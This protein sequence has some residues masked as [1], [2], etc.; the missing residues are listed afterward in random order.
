LILTGKERTHLIEEL[1]GEK[2]Q[3]VKPTATTP[4]KVDPRGHRHSRTHTS[5]QDTTPVRNAQSE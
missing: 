3:P 5:D 1:T 2:E 4:K